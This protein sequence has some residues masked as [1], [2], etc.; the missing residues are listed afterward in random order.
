M[1]PFESA[2]ALL[3]MPYHI[4]EADNLP[5]IRRDGLLPKNPGHNFGL[6]DAIA[7]LMDSHEISR[8]EAI[9]ILNKYAV[10]FGMNNAENLFDGRN[11]VYANDDDDEWAFSD[12]A[13]RG[14]QMQHPILLYLRN[15][16]N[17][18]MPDY[19]HT[20][21]HV[22]S[23]FPVKPQD[24]EI[25]HTFEPREEGEDDADYEEYLF[26]VMMGRA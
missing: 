17:E 24:I 7:D 13:E 22:R 15:N 6:E 2:W 14:S 18:W 11:W 19:G 23:P 8:E 1:S 16:E 12:L 9:D 21:R 10:S 5:S 26:N 4:T 25:E 20:T 3:K